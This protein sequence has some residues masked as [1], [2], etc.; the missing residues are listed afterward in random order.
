MIEPERWEEEQARRQRQFDEQHRLELRRI[1]R[2]ETL[3]KVGMAILGLGI[4][5]YFFVALVDVLR[6]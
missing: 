3:L 4:V 6:G 2:F 5:M 1:A